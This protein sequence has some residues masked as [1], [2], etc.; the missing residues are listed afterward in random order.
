MKRLLIY[1]WFNVR[2]SRILLLL[3]VLAVV[4]LLFRKWFPVS[5]SHIQKSKFGVARYKVS[6]NSTA[7]TLLVF[8]CFYTQ[9]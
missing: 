1:Y 2:W 6:C 4:G 3:A 7:H 8:Q 5:R 9:I